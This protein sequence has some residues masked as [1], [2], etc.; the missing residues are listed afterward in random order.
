MIEQLKSGICNLSAAQLAN[1][2]STATPDAIK[3][4]DG[5]IKQDDLNEPSMSDKFSM[6]KKQRSNN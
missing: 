6:F 1:F 5:G 2:M 3:K 4:K